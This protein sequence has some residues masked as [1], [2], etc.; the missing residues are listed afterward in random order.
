M[1]V[2]SSL[3]FHQEYTYVYVVSVWSCYNKET[4]RTS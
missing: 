3:V 4:N 1:M 2:N